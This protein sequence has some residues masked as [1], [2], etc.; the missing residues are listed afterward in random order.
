MTKL[1]ITPHTPQQFLFSTPS[2]KGA[3]GDTI[4]PGLDVTIRVDT[5]KADKEQL[6]KDLAAIFAE[7]LEYFE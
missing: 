6:K 7:V 2:I 1:S 4:K 3:Q 5:Y